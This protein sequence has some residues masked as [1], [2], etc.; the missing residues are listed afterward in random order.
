LT[1]PQGENSLQNTAGINR[2]WLIIIN[3]RPIANVANQ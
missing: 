1:A 3:P 2:Q